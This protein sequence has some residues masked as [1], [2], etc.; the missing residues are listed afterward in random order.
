MVGEKEQDEIFQ[1]IGNTL[2][3]RTEVIAI[4]GT[5]M[6]Y[7]NAKNRTKDIDLVAEKKEDF[8]L[9]KKTLVDMGYSIKDPFI[10]IKYKEMILDKPVFLVNKDLR[11]DLFLKKVMCIE[12]SEKMTSRITEI[13][14]YGNLI[15][16]IISP[17]DIILLKC[18]TDRAGD[19]E[20]ALS[21]INRMNIEW[22]IIID[23]C[24]EQAKLGELIFPV[25]FFDFLEEFKENFKANIPAEILKKTRIIAEN[26]MIK[27]LKNQSKPLKTNKE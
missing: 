23:E 26:E 6:I 16:K 5:A 19:R 21:L 7:Y 25:F 12:I 3:K 24:L 8:E 15:V 17:E 9:L 18:V 2:K 10:H 11:I 27:T 4:G 20:D 13:V 22:D 14:E 1:I